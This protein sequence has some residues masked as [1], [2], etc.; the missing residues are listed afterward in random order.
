[1]LH[2]SIQNAH[3]ERENDGFMPGSWSDRSRIVNFDFDPVCR[4]AAHLGHRK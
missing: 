1:M 4:A 3:G 2:F